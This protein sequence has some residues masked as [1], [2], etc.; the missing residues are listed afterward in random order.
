[1]S[2][3]IGHS[4]GRYHILEQLG[5]GGMATVYKAYDTRLETDVAVKVIR[6][7][8]LPQNAVERSLKRFEREAKALA[9]LTHPNIV[10]VTDYGE[11]ENHPYLVMPFLPGGTLKEK[12]NGKRMTWQEAVRLLIPIAR[13]LDFA[14]RQGMIHRDVKPSNI[15]ITADG[16]PMLTDFGIAKILD[17]QETMDLTATSALIGTP[18]YMAPEQATVKAADHRS[19]IYA[20]GI[21][22]YEMVTGRKPYTADTP[23]AV[24]IM[25]AR[26]PLPR[27]RTFV[28][29][30]PQVVESTLLKALAKKPEDRYQSMGEFAIALE[31]LERQTS[32]KAAN[33]KKAKSQ[34]VE[35]KQGEIGKAGF[36]YRKWL[37]I[38][39][40]VTLLGI[41]LAVGNVLLGL[42]WRV[43]E[44]PAAIT[45]TSTNKQSY[46]STQTSGQMPTYTSTPVNRP[47]PTYA[48]LG[49]DLPLVKRVIRDEKFDDLS[50]L[51]FQLN[52]GPQGAFNLSDGLLTLNEPLVSGDP[53]EDGSSALWSDWPIQHGNGY[54]LLFRTE[55]SAYFLINFEY[56]PFGS[57]D[58]HAF[59]F[60]SG[61]TYGIWSGDNQLISH[62]LGFQY[63]PKTW[64]YLLMWLNIDGVEGKIWEKDHPETGKLFTITTGKDWASSH[65]NYKVNVAEGT[66][67]IDEFQEVEFLK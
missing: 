64:Y 16:E 54:L 37:M 33:R 27:P 32:S 46:A 9:R 30:L 6:T 40:F 14:H 53:W 62:T 34:P 11:Y 39:G 42:G 43:V 66:M 17:A 7:E 63:E 18:E 19:D 41:S 24:T 26:D 13:A 25:H 35:Y 10:K 12:L 67:V 51:E 50:T 36:D 61:Q 3:L 28:S 22:L 29:D 23:L 5:E 59:W 58:Y 1:M 21:V 56:G 47:M 48:P 4:L 45:S 8:S 38:G 60:E 65:L 49:P 15:L 31:N 52:I 44:P 20:L 57:P 2:N 55:P